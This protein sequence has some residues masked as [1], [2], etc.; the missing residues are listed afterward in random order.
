[1]SIQP[2][3]WL[4][5]AIKVL[6][7]SFAVAMGVVILFSVVGLV[8]GSEVLRE[9]STSRAIMLVS[10]LLAIPICIKYLKK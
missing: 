3:K 7:A 9:T 8:S 5:Y 2:I 4:I 6:F 10:M 1:M